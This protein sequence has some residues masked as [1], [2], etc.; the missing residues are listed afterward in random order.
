MATATVGKKSS[1]KEWLVVVFIGFIQFIL[2]VANFTTAGC[3]ECAC[4]NL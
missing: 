1:E 3:S 4:A 2:V